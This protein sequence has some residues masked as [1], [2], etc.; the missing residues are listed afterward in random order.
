MLVFLI[1]FLACNTF[2]LVSVVLATLFY[3][4]TCSTGWFT[5]FECNWFFMHVA[6][7]YVTSCVS[8]KTS[9][10]IDWF[11]FMH[12]RIPHV[13]PVLADSFFYFICV[14]ILNSRWLLIFLM[15]VTFFWIIMHVYV[16]RKASPLPC[17]PKITRSG[18]F[19]F[20]FL[21]CFPSF[22][23]LLNNS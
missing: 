6:M 9:N 11:F 19:S 1:F 12:V 20:L 23:N 16:Q 21:A 14:F 18:E 5:N 7:Y 4:C 15:C 3:A 2:M 22:F 10:L 17:Y 13:L 8:L